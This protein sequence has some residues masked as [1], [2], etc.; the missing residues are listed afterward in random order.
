MG[1]VVATGTGTALA[2]IA[3][4]ADTAIRPPSPLTRQLG[5]VV[6]I[7]AVVA[8]VTGLALGAGALVLGLSP[9]SAFLFGVG[10]AVALVPEGLLPTVTLSLARGAQ[11]MASQSALV[12][13]LDAVETLGATTFICTDKTGTITQNRMAVVDVVTPVGRV[14]V[15]GV[16]YE[17][18]ARLHGSREAVGVVVLARTAAA[19]VAGRATVVEGGWVADGDPMEA[20][21]H[22]LALRCGTDA[23]G[24]GGEGRR[25]F[26]PDRML[27][28]AST[29]PRCP[30]SA[31]PNGCSAGAPWFPSP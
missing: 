30:F 18:V 7:V 2:E 11:L 10:V 13:R 26:S 17:P 20:A 29:A 27:P 9:T 1:Q 22:C 6:R 21:V 16:G 5:R 4:L 8:A 23:P 19:C 14:Q 15:T 12:R 31:H 25:P 3:R 24:A 28:R